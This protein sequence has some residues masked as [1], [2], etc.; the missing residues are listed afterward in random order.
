MLGTPEIPYVKR[1]ESSLLVADFNSSQNKLFIRLKAFP[2]HR[3]N[4]DFIC[5]NSP[6]QVQVSG[7][8]V[9]DK[10]KVDLKNSIYH[11]SLPFVHVNEIEEVVIDF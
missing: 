7:R 1:T 3:S 2:S 6:K 11:V 10:L 9:S 8:D 5:P 4:V